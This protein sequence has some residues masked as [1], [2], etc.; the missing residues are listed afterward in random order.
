MLVQR[1]SRMTD[2]PEI[3]RLAAASPVGVTALPADVERLA[4]IIEVS[5]ASMAEDVSFSGEE[6]YFFVMEDTQTGRLAG[7]SSIIA[8]AGFTEPFYTFRNEMFVHASRELGLHNRIH[9]L[10]LCHDLTGHSLL[11]GFYMQPAFQQASWVELNARGRLLFMANHPQRFAESTSVE[12]VGVSDE[13]GNAP[14]WDA[15]GRHFFAVS[16]SEAEQIGSSRGRSFLAELMPGYPI[17]VPMLSD[18][19]QEV[20]G[21]VHPSAQAIFD[22]L[23][24]EGFETDNYVDIFDGGPVVHART[25]ELH[26]ARDSQLVEVE[27]GHP[28]A[29][30]GNWLVANQRIGDFRAA[31]LDLAWTQNETLVLSRHDA[32]LLQVA[33]GDRLRLVRGA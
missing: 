10:S 18:A 22:V 7:C 31:C 23:M 25:A 15:L 21:Q 11:A 5:E 6:R 26:S 1:L 20:I 13:Q 12:I 2:L 4:N 24:R 33:T 27:V 16:Y 14:F 30:T 32:D 29:V 19:A 8:S 28:G 3:E 17:Y 9:V